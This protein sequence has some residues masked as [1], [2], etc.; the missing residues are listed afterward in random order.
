VIN[1]Q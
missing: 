1:T